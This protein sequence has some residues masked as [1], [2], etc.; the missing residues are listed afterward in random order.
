M[1]ERVELLGAKVPR[2]TSYPTAPHF[3]PGIAAQTFG[4]WLARLSGSPLSLYVHIPFCDTMCWFC[5]CHTRVVNNYSPVASYLDFLFTE[6]DRIADISSSGNFVTDIH[7]GGGSPTM[8]APRDIGRL[9]EHIASRFEIM[10]DANFAIEIDPRGL[11]DATVRALAEAEANRASV[12]V[13]DCD[14]TVQHAINR[15]QP[16]DVTRDAA[17]RLRTAGIGALNIDLIYGLPHQTTAHL[18]KTIAA[19]L[20]LAPD[21]LAVFGYAHVPHFKK[22]QQL[23]DDR[24]LPG[25]QDRLEQFELAHTMLTEAG[26]TAIGF[27]HFAKPGDSMAIAQAEG[28]LSRNFQGYTTDAAPALIGFGASS[29]SALPQG[30]AQNHSG[31]PDYRNSIRAGGLATARGIQLTHDDRVRRAIIEKLMCNLF[32]DLETLCSQFGVRPD[33]FESE[34]AALAPLAMQGIVRIDGGKIFVEPRERFAIRLVCAAF[35]TYLGKSG[36]HHALA[37]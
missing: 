32:V 17:D 36:A 12:G 26:Y 20:T 23:I 31:V 15:I 27:D 25:L 5:G 9:A 13:Q 29:I 7:W 21:R 37:V 18:E 6:I 10:P 34:L 2:Y 22:H 14:A 11:T 28:Q 19:V 8:L 3:H 33:A 30:Y 4:E 16:F 24:A 35:D 1:I